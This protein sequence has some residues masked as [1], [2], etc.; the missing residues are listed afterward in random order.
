MGRPEIQKFAGALLGQKAKKGIF[1]TTSSFTSD[2]KSYAENIEAKIV[3]LDGNML[4]E[5]M[6]ENSLGVNTVR[7]YEIKRLDSD[8][9]EE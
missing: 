8:Y 1:I 2:A 9:F 5:L 6:I 3:L 7:S 4:S